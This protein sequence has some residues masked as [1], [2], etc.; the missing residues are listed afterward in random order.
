VVLDQ[1]GQE[2]L[3]RVRKQRAKLLVSYLPELDAAHVEHLI[4]LLEQIAQA[5]TNPTPRST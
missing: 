1:G 2:L 3:E 4:A 5:A